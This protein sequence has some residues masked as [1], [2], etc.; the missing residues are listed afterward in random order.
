MKM[1]EHTKAI[2]DAMAD[3]ILVIDRDYNIVFANKSMLKCCGTEESGIIGKKC[4]D[5]LHLCP[6]PCP[7]KCE[8]E[9]CPYAV[10]FKKGKSVSVIHSHSMHD[11]TERIFDITA[12]P[13][14][15][16]KGEVVFMIEVLRDV[17]ELKKTEKTLHE[18]KDFLDN[19]LEGIGEGVVV[20]D[21][22]L[23]IIKANRG[24]CE[25]VKMSLEEIIGEHCYKISHGLD[26]P[27]YEKTN[28]CECIVKRCFE[29]GDCGRAIHTHYDK[30]GET[31]YI[32]T[33][34]YPLRDSSGKIVYVIES[35]IDVTDMVKLEKQLEG[36]K[37]RYRKLYDDA[38]DM[39]HSL[40]EDGI[41]LVCN[42]TEAEALGYKIEELIGRKVIEIIPLES[43][44]SCKEKLEIVKDK[45]LYEGEMKLLARDGKRISVIVKSK[46]V[47]D[48]N[49]NFLFTDAILRDITS[50]K[51]LEDQLMQAQKM[52]A[53][54][55][56]AGGIAHDFNNILTAI[57]GYGSMLQ[58]KIKEDNPL[59]SNIDQILASCERAA[60]L[61][62]SLLTF[63]RKQIINP[64]PVK[65]NEIIKKVE[66]FLLR[67][68][69]EDI[70][71]KTLLSDRDLTVIADSGQIEQVLMNLA[72]NARNAMP[73]G[74]TLTI[75][76]DIVELDE[77]FISIY[78]Y[79]KPGMHAL[80]SITDTGRGMDEKTREKIFE[81]F[82]TTKEAG[83]GT[84]LGLSMVY[85][86]IKQHGGYIN[87]YSE[88]GKGTT[89]KIYL[90]ITKTEAA[91]GIKAAEIVELK[92]GTET[93][94]LAE[95]EK[96]V[97]E[98]TRNILVESG[99]KVIEAVDGVDTVNKFMKNKDKVS[100]LLLD[101]VIPKISGKEAYEKIK[102]MNPD[103]KALF[104][105]GY[106]EDMIQKHSLLEEGLNFI[107]K[108]VSPFELLKKIRSVLDN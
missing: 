23:R 75:N 74:G 37:E 107:A 19:I 102:K 91:K 34:A 13:I 92:C 49:G 7:E 103:I 64:V 3:G 90:P 1:I 20:L 101:V 12:S 24:Y 72:T 62:R 14:L 61:T 29:T 8:T 57:I 60:N 51:K 81:P 22:G 9:T 80:I 42:K 40:N 52:E 95:D 59:R 27:C 45:G 98:L 30:K 43:R 86:I 89:F 25:Q 94:L 79:G 78:G 96:V 77:I 28:G 46:A 16:E 82:F 71:L 48:D 66:K 33:N 106:P 50:F 5:L 32:E 88:A 69:G 21:R 38:P 73:D 41:I 55:Q 97:R 76:T 35:L 68:I 44:D 100:L 31:L 10:I 47:Y 36:S 2:H 56:L 17:T 65:L 53:V 15:D 87:C 58:M 105:S 99:Y 104:I 11:G 39:M 18:T 93:I 54:G 108:P 6:V 84:G 26:V 85:G 67:I 83:K 4:H 63:S 70:E